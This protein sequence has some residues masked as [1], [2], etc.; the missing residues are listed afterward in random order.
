[1]KTILVIEDN[2]R[3]SKRIKR[4]ILKAFAKEVQIL[5]ADTFET[6]I[7]LIEQDV[8]DI[9]IIDLELA[10]GNGEELLKIIRKRSHLHPVILQ[11]II[12]DV[13]YQLKIFQTYDRVKYLT[14]DVLFDKLTVSLDWA[15]RERAITTT[16][17]I[18][19][20]GRVITDSLNVFE[21]CFI[22]KIPNERHLHVE[23]YDFESRSYRFAEIRNM[24]LDTFLSEYNQL[25][26]F[27]RCHQSFIVNKKMV[28]QLH[29]FDDEIL[30]LFRGENNREIRIPIGGTRKKDVLNELKGLY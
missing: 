16:H 19:I 5:I 10:N 24:S 13:A 4:H 15:L 21:I 1:M 30:M 14:K 25:G 28:E 2:S 27:L 26:I 17:R 12:H 20:P 23:L 18:S 22:E 9:F 7:D 3:I 6:A 8:A 11:S 29:H